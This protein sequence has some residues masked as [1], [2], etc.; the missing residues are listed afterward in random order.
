MIDWYN[1]SETVTV[2][3]GQLIQ[4]H[5]GLT[6]KY[7]GS[8]LERDVLVLLQE[9]AELTDTDPQ[10]FVCELVGDV[11]S[12]GSKFPSLQSHTMEDTEEQ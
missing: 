6:I 3:W 10:V 4:S 11:E 8:D 5:S 1:T 9:H 2:A 12:K 7:S